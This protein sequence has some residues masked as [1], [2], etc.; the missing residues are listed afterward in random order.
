M[1]AMRGALWAA[2]CLMLLAGAATGAGKDAEKNTS[3]KDDGFARTFG[4]AKSD[5]GP[6]GR[7]D[8]FILEPGYVMTLEGKEDGKDAKLVITVLP[9]TRE[10]DGVKT[11]VVEERESEDGKIVEIS[12]N[13]F[14]ISARTRNVYYF[15]EDSRDYEDGNETGAEGSWL[16]GANGASYGLI[17]PAR[18]KVGEKYYQEIAPRE[19]AMDRAETVSLD[20]K[21]TVPAGTFEKCLKVRESS[22][23]EPG[24][25]FKLYAPGVGLLQDGGLKLTQYGKQ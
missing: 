23:A 4:E 15:G 11:R 2:A 9:E 21:V 14:A 1:N 16:A 18:P 13:Y 8:Y 6:T 12:R 7:N 3:A 19:K 5:L 24:E 22:A 10:V 25:E 20:E 17:M